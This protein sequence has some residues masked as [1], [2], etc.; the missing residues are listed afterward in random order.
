[1]TND[2]CARTTAHSNNQDFL[3]FARR[4]PA[5]A[6]RP[7]TRGR[8]I[9]SNLSRRQR[10]HCSLGKIRHGICDRR[11]KW[12]GH[13]WL[14]E[15]YGLEGGTFFAKTPTKSVAALKHSR[16]IRVGANLP[17]LLNLNLPNGL[18]TLCAE[19]GLPTGT[20]GTDLCDI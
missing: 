3:R 2:S 20:R 14:F 11:L 8:I 9:F 17:V 19:T 12:V 15:R 1:M 16:A 6:T 4:P 7:N 13:D 18:S 10:Q 5:K